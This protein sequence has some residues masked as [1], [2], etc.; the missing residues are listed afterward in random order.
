VLRGGIYLCS[1]VR[2]NHVRITPIDMIANAI[3]LS[4]INWSFSCLSANISLTS[5]KLIP[6]QSKCGSGFG[7]GPAASSPVIRI[8][9]QNSSGG[10][11]IGITVSY[12]DGLHE[13]TVT[14]DVTCTLL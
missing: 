6:T 4:V 14:G 1:R 11:G 7:G 3:R 5:I 13:G 8:L 10:C 2:N 9:I 12:E